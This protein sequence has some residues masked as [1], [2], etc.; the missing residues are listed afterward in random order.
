ML[1]M[2]WHTVEKGRYEEGKKSNI[3]EVAGITTVVAAKEH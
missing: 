1:K 3:L 2:A